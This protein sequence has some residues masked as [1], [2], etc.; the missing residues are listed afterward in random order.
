MKLKS[1][2]CGLL[3]FLAFPLFSENQIFNL[4]FGTDG[5]L[6]GSGA[7]LYG[8]YF[9]FDKILK[10]D[11]DLPE[12]RV[13]DK[14]AVNP[15]DRPFMK[16]YNKKLDFAGTV[17]GAGVMASA[18]ILAFA[19]SSEWIT[20]GTMYGETLLWAYS[21]KCMGK[22]IAGRVR[23]Y[24]YFDNIPEEAITESDWNDSFPSAHSTFVFAAAGFTSYV[25]SKYFPESPW[26]YGVIAG[27]YAVATVTAGLRVASGNHFLSDVFAGAA[28]GS[29]CGFLIP[30]L[31]T[32]SIAKP[33]TF[34]FGP[35]KSAAINIVP[36]GLSGLGIIM[37]A[38]I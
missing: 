16:P 22:L 28:I 21:L 24:M 35:F 6:L 23:P 37:N 26:Q 19:P 25:F 5:I 11:S 8:T 31:H 36:A 33:I 29:V 32:L 9:I 12:G 13:F 1:I 27:T 4:S 38:S 15:F 17:V 14:N 20:I 3:L 10:V 7:A 18:G 2:F 30:F 34:N